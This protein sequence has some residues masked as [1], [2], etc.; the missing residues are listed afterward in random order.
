M[1]THHHVRKLLGR[2]VK[3]HTIFGTFHG[4]VI[5]CSKHH[6]ILGAV[7]SPRQFG[8]GP[9]RPYPMGPWGGPGMPGGGWHVAIPLA[10][11]LG[12]TAI[13]LHWW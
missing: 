8:T 2:P 7:T 5:H 3:C 11:I 4:I 12:I 1:V 10:A 13:G 9:Y 6:I